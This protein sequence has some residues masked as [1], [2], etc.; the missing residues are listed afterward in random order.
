MG[1]PVAQESVQSQNE[2]VHSSNS[3]STSSNM[4]VNGVGDDFIRKQLQH[5]LKDRAFMLGI[6]NE[7]ITFLN[8]NGR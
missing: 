4:I 2:A 5:N 1:E 7:L 8:A 3:S 6:E